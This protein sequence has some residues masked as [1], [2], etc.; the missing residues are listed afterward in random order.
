MR[1]KIPIPGRA[2]LAIVLA[3]FGIAGGLAIS[4]GPAGAGAWT[5]PEGQG[6]LIISSGRKSRP[7]GALFGGFAN[8]DETSLQ[9]YAEYGLSDRLTIGGLVWTELVTNTMEL[10]IEIGAH[11]RY[12]L[13]KGRA[14]DVFSA[15]I[16][17]RYPIAT[18]L[19]AAPA[20]SDAA[21]PSAGLSLLYGR[22]W[23][24]GIGDLFASAEA[25]YSW[26]GG[27]EADELRFEQTAGI[28]A[29]RWIMGIVSLYGAAPMGQGDMSLKIAPSIAYTFWPWNAADRGRMPKGQVP[30]TVQLGIT[31]D[32][33]N[34]DHGLALTLSIWRR[35]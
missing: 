9:F 17:A 12:R 3:A 1:P 25:G 15:Q 19:G 35:F 14:G 27:A 34:P 32:M 13:W 18:G 22:G 29:N 23:Q 11:A 31:W 16:A 20:R 8:E 28:K 6:I 5:L 26:Q 10:G 24:S 30:A 4:T 21:V 2:A 33:L 7:A